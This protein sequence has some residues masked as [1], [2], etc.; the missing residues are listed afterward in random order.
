[1]TRTEFLVAYIKHNTEEI[2]KAGEIIDWMHGEKVERPNILT[3][4]AAAKAQ[5]KEMPD[6]F[7]RVI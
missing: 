5:W 1:M 6:E 4:I 3:F 7:E 2:C